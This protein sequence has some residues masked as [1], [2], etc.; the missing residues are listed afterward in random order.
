[1]DLQEVVKPDTDSPLSPVSL[2]RYQ[3]AI[4]IKITISDIKGIMR[5]LY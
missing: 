1:M 2:R 4:V 3:L 5:K